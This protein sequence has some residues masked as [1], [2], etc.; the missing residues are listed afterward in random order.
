MQKP[1]STKTPGARAIV[2]MLLGACHALAAFVALLAL[3][4]AT[5]AADLRVGVAS[6][7]TP[8]AIGAPPSGAARTLVLGADILFKER[9]NTD[10]AGRAQIIFLDHSS[11]AIAPSS[12]LAIDEFVYD[13]ARGAGSL[14]LSTSRGLLRYIGGKISKG[15]DVTFTTPV[16]VIAIRG[17]MLLVEVEL[18]GRTTA[19]FLYGERMTVSAAGVTRTVTRPGYRVIVEAA[20]EPPSSPARAPQAAIDA[21]FAAFERNAPPT[22]AADG[23]ASSGGAT[24]GGESAEA[25][26]GDG[27]LNP[28]GIIA[29]AGQ[30]DAS[31]PSG[32]PAGANSPPLSPPLG[33][34]VS[35]AAIT[36]QHIVTILNSSPLPVA[37]MI[38][39]ATGSVGTTLAR[40]T[41][42][43]TTAVANTL[44]SAT[45]AVGSTV[46]GV[47][48]GLGTTVAGLGTVV[49]GLG[50]TVANVASP[51]Q[52]VAAPVG[53]LVSSVGSAVGALAPTVT[54][55]TSVVPAL[56]GTVAAATSSLT[57][58]VSNL[59]ATAGNSVAAPASAA[60][61][62][63]TATT[64][65]SPLT[66]AVA[67]AATS[68]AST[69]ATATTTAAATT[70]TVSVLTKSLT[71][72]V[73]LP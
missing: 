34:I 9:I 62:A 20:G 41:T 7:V 35:D 18:S 5:A 40:T 66:S 1:S 39:A 61:A 46:A 13:P 19:T 65:A 37:A 49:S 22:G 10:R 33:P 15:S 11:L 12:S 58:A 3:S 67:N 4:E 17:G 56:T 14:A 51:L 71:S 69:A 23:G 55:V 28:E 44:S 60:G 29:A 59:A 36:D 38:P 70:K 73:K 31:A 63:T 26:A 68:L 42:T 43:A 24:L 47:G 16:A 6:A 54:S 8:S 2:G 48:T 32:T 52:P 25:T 64:A 30:A 72:S 21:A 53:A 45:T 50:T 57:G 27:A